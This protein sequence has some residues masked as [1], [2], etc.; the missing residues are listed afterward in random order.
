MDKVW[1]KLRQTHYPPGPE[2]AILAGNGDDSHAPLCLGHCIAD[3]KHI[4][5]PINS[6][7]VVAFPMRMNVF[8]S[9]VI[10]FKW[11]RTSGFATSLALVASAPVAAALG[12][13]T[14]KASVGL[15]FKRSVSKHEE[16][17]R[18]D[19]YIVQPSRR[20]VEQ[21]LETD[22]LKRYIG[23]K[24][25]WS[26]FLIT[27]IRVARAGKRSGES[28]KNVV[29]RGGPDQ[30]YAESG[31]LDRT[32]KIEEGKVSDFVWAIRLAKIHKGFL[33]TDWSMGPYTRRATF[34]QEGEQQ[35]DVGA[36]VE[37]EGLS[38]FQVVEDDDLGEA[39]VMDAEQWGND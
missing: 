13:G 3:L 21:C 30:A 16:Y 28:T 34:G 37:G 12:L 15:A 22:E 23:N 38:S 1:F 10:D 9:H 20:Y 19:T 35:V 32:E 33:M 8:Q 5:F 7:A 24:A 29:A 26:F 27:G 31:T 25:D 17:E 2:K 39:I 36:V 6:G 14:V 11:E 4:D 18:L